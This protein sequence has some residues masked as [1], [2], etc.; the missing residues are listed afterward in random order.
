[1]ELNNL[2]SAGPA[3][4]WEVA[5]GV[6][7]LRTLFVNVAFVSLPASSD[8]ILVDT[9]LGKF[10]RT[11]LDLARERFDKPPVSIVLT[12]G[13]FD[14]VGTVKE[15]VEEWNVPVYA[16]PLELPYLTGQ[17]DYPEAD[18]SVRGGLMAAA[19]PLYPHRA[20]DLG[21]AVRPLPEDGSIPGAE[22]WK[23]VHS[24]GHSPGHIS[25]FR[26][27]DKVLLAGDAFLTV[28]Q[29]S[30]LAVVTQHQKIH[31]PPAY[32]TTDWEEAEQSVR[33]LALLDPRIVLTGHGLPMEGP[34]MSAQLADLCRFFKEKA[35]PQQGKFV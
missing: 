28:K 11:I 16:H 20:I 2:L 3:A 34:E 25:L 30:A 4:L 1:M 19:A 35:I 12:H 9:G 26:A 29:E 8:W 23:W 27:R 6:L 21:S 14:H 15:L 22:E 13:H 24:P 18:P 31:G 10:G 17:T 7:G 33:N 5:P 32:F